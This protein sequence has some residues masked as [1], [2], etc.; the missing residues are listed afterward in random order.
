MLWA[1]NRDRLQP[2]QPTELYGTIS[3]INLFSLGTDIV[4][5]PI[6]RLRESH[7]LF[8]QQIVKV[9]TRE[10]Q[11]LIDI[12]NCYL[13]EGNLWH[14]LELIDICLAPA[15]KPNKAW[16]KTSSQ[17]LCNIPGYAE[18]D[19]TGIIRYEL[20][21]FQTINMQHGMLMCH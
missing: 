5:V 13:L 11:E 4:V 12:W 1:S 19:P 20:T 8:P 2:A 21:V 6:P 9:D 14:L 15:S 10:M 7:K 16:K 18:L 3:F 17:N